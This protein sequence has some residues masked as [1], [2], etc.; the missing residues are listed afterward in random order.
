MLALLALVIA[1]C[2]PKSYS[3]TGKVTGVNGEPLAGVKILATGK[4]NMEATTN[5]KGEW[6]L[7]GLKG[8]TT[9]QPHMANRVFKP[10]KQVVTALKNNVNFAAQ[11]PLV[12]RMEGKGTVSFLTSAGLTTSPSAEGYA[13]GEKVTF[14]AEPLQGWKFSDWSGD[15][16]GAKPSF[17]IVMDGPK[18]INVK[19]VQGNAIIFFEDPDLESVVRKA[20]N[21][22]I[23]SITRE[24][25]EDLTH[26]NASVTSIQSLKGIENLLGLSWLDLSVTDT[27]AISEL[28]SLTKLTY[29]NLDSNQIVDIHALGKLVQLSELRLNNNKINDVTSLSWL[30]NKNLLKADLA[31]NQ[32]TNVTALKNLTTLQTLNLGNN[33]ITDITPLGSLRLIRELDLSANLIDKIDA[34]TLMTRLEKLNLRKNKLNNIE[35]IVWLQDSNLTELNLSDNLIVDINKVGMLNKLVK[36]NLANN[37]VVNITSLSNL[38]NLQELNLSGN[39][40]VDIAPLAMLKSVEKLFLHKNAMTDIRPLL[41]MPAL[42][43][44]TLMD[45]KLN[46]TT[47]LQA[48]NVIQELRK[49][50]VLV[51]YDYYQNDA[52]IIKYPDV[53]TM[54]INENQEL[55]F[56]VVAID[57]N[58]DEMTYEATG[59]LKDYFDPVSHVF[60]WT[61]S[62]DDAGVHDVTFVVRDSETFT[63]KKLTIIVNNVNRAPVFTPA[64]GNKTVDETKTLT[65]TI[66]AVDPDQD[67]VSYSVDDSPLKQ[68]F[69]MQTLTFN[70]TPTYEDAG[71]Y[72]MTFR[73]TDGD[74]ESAETITITVN[75]VNRI[76]VLHP[77]SDKTV[78]EMS[79]LEFTISGED[80]DKEDTLVYSAEGP[81][82]DKFDPVNRKFSW[83]PTYDQAG[84]YTI[85]F[86]VSDGRAS[87]TQAVKITVNNVDRAPVFE[88]TPDQRIDEYSILKFTIRAVDPDGDAV[89]YSSANLPTKATLNATTGEFVWMPTREHIGPQEITFI[90]TAKNK[91]ASMK[92]MILVNDVAF[93]PELTKIGDRVVNEGDTLKFTVEAI[94]KDGDIPTYRVEGD[95][96]TQF[97]NPNTRT[98]EWKPD[99][100]VTDG[101]PKV[102]TITFYASDGMH[103]VSE[104]IKITVNNTN[105]PPEIIVLTDR[106]TVDENQ[107]VRFQVAVS[108][109]DGDQV[110]LVVGGKLSSFYDMI[111]RIFTWTPGWFDSGQHTVTFMAN[112]GKTSTTKDVV[113]IVNNVDRPPVFHDIVEKTVE[114]NEYQTYSLQL[115]AY[116]PDLEPINYTASGLP[117]GATLNAKTGLFTWTPNYTHANKEF[118]VTF[119]VGFGI[120]QTVLFKVKDIA[121]PPEFTS[122]T[123]TAFIVNEGQL[124]SFLVEAKDKDNDPITYDIAFPNDPIKYT[125]AVKD[126][127][128]AC[129][130]RA[131]NMFQWTPSHDEATSAGPI[132]YTVRFKASDGNVM[133]EVWKEVTIT[134]MN[135]DRKPQFTVAEQKIM[136]KDAGM[137]TWD[138]A[139][140]DLDGE[141]ITLTLDNPPTGSSFN[142]ISNTVVNGVTT[143][144]AQLA[145]NPTST[146]VGDHFLT[147]T[148]VAGG[149]TVKKTAL[150]TVQ[151]S[152]LLVT[153]LTI[154]DDSI[155]PGEVTTLRAEVKNGGNVVTG[156]FIAKWEILGKDQQGNWVLYRQLNTTPNIGPL[157]VNGSQLV[158]Y[159]L[160]ADELRATLLPY[161]EYWVRMTVDP[162][163]SSGG[164]TSK[165]VRFILERPQYLLTTNVTG[166]GT[167]LRS[168]TSTSSTYPE[169]TVVTLTPLPHD[170]WVFERWE[171]DPV[172]QV[173][174]NYTLTMTAD[175]T[176]T[177]VFKKIQLPYRMAF[178]SKRDDLSKGDIF[179]MDLDST[180][181]KIQTN[182][183]TEGAPKW[184]YR[185]GIGMQI[186]FE[187]NSG[188]R[189]DIYLV[190]PDGTGL[191]NLTNGGF[192]ATQFMSPAWSP[193]GEKITFAAKEYGNFDI[194]VMNLN[195]RAVQRMTLSST[196]DDTPIWAP[197]ESFIVCVDKNGSLLK[198]DVS[199]PVNIPPVSLNGGTAASVGKNPVWSPDGRRIA[200]EANSDIY[201]IE[202]LTNT[203][204]PYT[205]WI[206]YRVTTSSA[207]DHSPSW[208]PDSRTLTF[209]SDRAGSDDIYALT[210]SFKETEGLAIRLS[211]TDLED[212]SEC[213]WSPDGSKLIFVSEVSGSREI[214]MMNPNG[215]EVTRLTNNNVDDSA[216]AWATR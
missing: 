159:L 185:S 158:N 211:V 139:V 35:K 17:T 78:D 63:T 12:F 80:P 88:Q 42:K 202:F 149:Q 141:P 212:E 161:G 213:K 67:A 103:E 41:E 7:N 45:N 2:G 107:Q 169:D 136:F 145:W 82:S 20:I 90:A 46:L 176:V 83:T 134:I 16:N 66:H 170:G 30:A 114:I 184:F 196:D 29:L 193:T 113:I 51:R 199:D 37:K 24:D 65:F 19:F 177:A 172:V 70:W 143:T 135:V 72:Q 26:L 207:N 126:K 122:P 205:Q 81:F 152:R 50:N 168:P 216:P 93:A 18:Q 146:D 214:F 186:L 23:G 58:R 3:V 175:R 102:F 154:D 109:A 9:I 117:T 116:D 100:N 56:T 148:A 171:G 94:D 86:K 112:D 71:T 85:V 165:E 195:T 28:A 181:T 61:P 200:F 13:L 48:Y 79:L 111:N 55:K 73:A 104:T 203:P 198:I 25:V 131:T 97:F 166:G 110:S 44:V 155:R 40:I 140:Q 62:Y 33:Q 137:Q 167:I 52:P 34:I 124:V 180:L 84:T 173:G 153:Y 179:V 89:V 11:F 147:F 188:T 105:R 4:V 54:T 14:T 106:W 119:S 120:S 57:P 215:T 204:K 77:I 156:Q 115:V 157:G 59:K 209:I 190:N 174:G 6:Q 69:N 74:K 208:S 160:S 163:G 197:D 21:K 162:T 38:K 39:Q 76:P 10:A 142:I 118:S 32:I 201:M 132:S 191:T 192:T 75:N 150:L 178:L 164:P 151:G 91:T 96:V 138:I 182:G 127:L 133:N 1:G 128:T 189:R 53:D 60:A 95:Y 130:N 98:F 31:N 22:P 121:F 68:Y 64:I 123:E 101:L 92:V 15:W 8:S 194:F 187:G 49:R 99:F 206:V 210:D 27:T 47:G 108:D 129:F 5:A 183:L 144:T 125:Q 87:A 43:E 36:L